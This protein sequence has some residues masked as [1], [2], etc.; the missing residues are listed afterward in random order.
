MTKFGETHQYSAR[1]FVGRLEEVLKRKVDGV[2]CNMQK[3]A[4]GI[5]KEYRRQKAEFVK[6]DTRHAF[7]GRRLL[8]AG[9]L[10]DTSGG[11]VRHDSQKL[12]DMLVDIIG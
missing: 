12:A 2:L 9:D 10:L 11:I 7:W 1:T 5:L 4:A 3:P 8:Y 6:I